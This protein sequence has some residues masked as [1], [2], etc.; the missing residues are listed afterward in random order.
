MPSSKILALCF[1]GCVR[2]VSMAKHLANEGFETKSGGVVCDWGRPG[3]EEKMVWA[4]KILMMDAA[5][6]PY[7]PP[8]YFSK[9]VLS[10]VGGDRWGYAAHPELCAKVRAIIARWKSDGWKFR[11]IYG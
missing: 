7:V 5:L 2:S 9:V 10:H 1:A 6:L 11:S 4:D 3:L 8:R